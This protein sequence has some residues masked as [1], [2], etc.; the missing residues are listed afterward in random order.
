M[1]RAC[2]VA[3][4]CLGA[5]ARVRYNGHPEFAHLTPSIEAALG[6]HPDVVVIGHGNVALDVA[7]IL[8]KAATAGAH[9]RTIDSTA[10]STAEASAVAT[11]AVSAAPDED[12]R[13]GSSGEG[14]GGSVFG[15][16]AATDI[17]TPAAAALARVAARHY[18]KHGGAGLR[19]VSVVGRRG[20]AQVFNL[21]PARTRKKRARTHTHTHNT[22]A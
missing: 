19:R 7:R 21:W 8:A 17:V 16:L 3:S 14:D 11:A 12:Y 4:W 18:A 20:A 6:R 13:S 1:N 22:R 10:H 5:F 9:R 15:A 2:D